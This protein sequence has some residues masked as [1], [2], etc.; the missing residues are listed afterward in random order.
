M[1]QVEEA[2]ARQVI[3]GGDLVTNLLEVARVD[4]SVLTVLL[5]E[6]MRLAPAPAG[7]LPRASDDVRSLVPRE[8]ALQRS[9]VPLEVQVDGKLVLAV[10]E[11]LPADLAEQLRFALGMSLEQRAAPAVRVH[12]ALA[13]IYGVPLDRRMLRLIARLGGDSPELGSTPPPLG[14]SAVA[15]EP[16]GP[17]DASSARERTGSTATATVVG[18]LVPKAPGHRITNAG[19]PAAPPVPAAAPAPP[20]GP[21]SASAGEPAAAASPPPPVVETAQASPPAPAVSPVPPQALPLS[22]SPPPVA[23]ASPGEVRGHLLQRAVSMVPRPVRRR[24]GPITLD[25]ARS[26]ADEAADRDALLDLFFDFSQQFFDYSA[27]FLVHGDIAEG[28]DAFGGGASRE[29]VLGI[30]VPLDMPSMLSTVREKRLSVIAKPPGD[31][32]DAVLL[33]DLHRARD[34]EMAIVPLVVRTRAVALLIGDCGDAGI[35]RESVQQVVAFSGVVGKAFERIIVRR[36]LDGFIAGGRESAAGRVSSSMVPPKSAGGAAA[37]ASKATPS[38]PPVASKPPPSFSTALAS[39]P[40]PSFTRPAPSSPPVPFVPKRAA[41]SRAPASTSGL[42]PPAANVAVV[43]KIAGPPIPREEPDTPGEVHAVVRTSPPPARVAPV[44][45]VPA[46]SQSSPELEIV[47][48][49]VAEPDEVSAT[50]LF[51]ELGWDGAQSP[52]AG[53]P[54]SSAVA[55]AAHL[56]PA[57]VGPV[58]ELPSIIVDDLDADLVAMVD[59]LASGE[60]DEAAEGELLRQGERAMRAIMSRFPGP[61][62]F[63]RARIATANNPPRASDCGPILRLVARERRVALPFVLDRLTAAEAEVRGWAAHLV[64]E[65]PY[66]EAIPRLLPCLRDLD[67]SVSASSAL[68]L[69]A[70]AR[71]APEPVRDALFSLAHGVTPADRAAAVGAMARAARRRL[72]P[73]ARARARRHRRRASS[74][75]PTP[76]SCR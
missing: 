46:P 51:D 39:A 75:S 41:A 18:R 7:E 14:F 69:A 1:R 50:A 32:L 71:S 47:E 57:P 16:A 23:P 52:E 48:L 5:A 66:V 29:R 26:E 20:S 74:L 13:R 58:Q 33:T 53:L 73:R 49:E 70:I 61:V 3:Y 30:G 19:F 72:R 2:L 40:P 28:R 21:A 54:P 64:I 37:V 56:P 17:P 42:P 31:G 24:R 45:R 68:A 8:I 12:Q 55:V 36:K 15:S 10:A 4:E 11:P 62:S 35:D 67:A 59:R 43:R 34:S 65:L 60:V 44:S 38:A 76:A 63:S 25:L 6:S 27:L 9:V 22:P